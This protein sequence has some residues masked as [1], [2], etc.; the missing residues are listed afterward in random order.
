MQS[1]AAAAAAAAAAR[2]AICIEL[3]PARQKSGGQGGWGKVQKQML[4]GLLK[5]LLCNSTEHWNGC[6]WVKGIWMWQR[7]LHADSV[8]Y[9]LIGLQ[10]YQTRPF[11]ERLLLYGAVR[12]VCSWIFC[13]C[14]G[15]AVSM[16]CP[17][18]GT[19]CR[20]TALRWH[21]LVANSTTVLVGHTLP[22]RMKSRKPFPRLNTPVRPVFKPE[23]TAVAP[24]VAT[25]AT[26]VA[27]PECTVA[28]PDLMPLLIAPNG[29]ATPSSFMRGMVLA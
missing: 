4:Q 26:P 14:L 10:G 3:W 16:P 23:L 13:S 20:A 9:M 5:Q 11:G 2:W 6:R 19:C 27:T 17:H 8:C 22:R 25:A 18:R 28:T 7:V 29:W 1:E 24:V 12:C 21:L 15:E